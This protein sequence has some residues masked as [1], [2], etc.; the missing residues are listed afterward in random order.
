MSW[1]S[2]LLWF[3]D[4]VSHVLLRK[5]TYQL[6]GNWL[7]NLRGISKIQSRLTFLLAPQP[8]LDSDTGC[9][10]VT[11]RVFI[12]GEQNHGQH[13]WFCALE[14]L[15]FSEIAFTATQGQ[16]GVLISEPSKKF[17]DFSMQ[18]L[19]HNNISLFLSEINSSTKTKCTNSSEGS[20]NFYFFRFVVF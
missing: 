15:M 12:M 13:F 17:Y 6:Q 16:G 10:L 7:C 19:L 8:N 14:K 9:Q 1:N 5:G 3:C 20:T 4:K 2:I 11:R 18:P